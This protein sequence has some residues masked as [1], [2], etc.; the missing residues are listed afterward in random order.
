MWKL[1]FDPDTDTELTMQEVVGLG[2]DEPTILVD[3]YD[4]FSAV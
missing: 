4:A 2:Y 1:I 3:N